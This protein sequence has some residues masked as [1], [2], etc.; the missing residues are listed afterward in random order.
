MVHIG[1]FSVRV[2]FLSGVFFRLRHTPIVKS[3]DVCLLCP[4]LASHLLLYMVE[5]ISLLPSNKQSCFWRVFL[6]GCLWTLSSSITFVKTQKYLSIFYKNLRQ[7]SQEIKQTKYFVVAT[8]ATSQLIFIALF[9]ITFLYNGKVFTLLRNDEKI[10]KYIKC[11]LYPYYLII[12]IY[13]EFLLL[14]CLIQSYR[15]RKLPRNFNE[16]KLISLGVLLAQVFLLSYLIAG[17]GTDLLTEILML[18]AANLSMVLNMYGWKTFVLLFRPHLNDVRLL[19]QDL[20]EMAYRKV[21]KQ[22][23]NESSI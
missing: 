3:S 9:V 20:L 19:N 6:T 4:H 10:I 5:M 18:N 13:V 16:T 15:A 7:T 11:T 23:E 1:N 14:I 21:D 8:I 17:K 2:F 12:F 22:I